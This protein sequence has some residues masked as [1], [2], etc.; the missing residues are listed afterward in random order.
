MIPK[1]AK[2]TVT[3]QSRLQQNKSFLELQIKKLDLDTICEK[4]IELV[5]ICGDNVPFVE[6]VVLRQH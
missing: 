5:A 2:Q 4:F 3:Y 1:D 6:P